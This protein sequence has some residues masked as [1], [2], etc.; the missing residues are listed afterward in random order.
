MV[1]INYRSALAMISHEM[2]IIGIS[3]WEYQLDF[4]LIESLSIEQKPLSQLVREK[5][6]SK[7]TEDEEI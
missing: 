6:Q 4:I 1:S 7:W 5:R 2:S 3:D